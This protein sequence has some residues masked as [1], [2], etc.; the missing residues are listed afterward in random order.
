MEA[1]NCKG[2]WTLHIFEEN[3]YTEVYLNRLSDMLT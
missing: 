3:L 1:I 2:N